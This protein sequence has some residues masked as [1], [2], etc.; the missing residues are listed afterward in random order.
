MTLPN[1]Q[2]MN[3]PCLRINSGEDFLFLFICC[4]FG[5]V[6]DKFCNHL[7]SHFVDFCLDFGFLGN[8]LKNLLQLFG[9]CS[10]G[11]CLHYFIGAFF[12]DFADFRNHPHIKIF[13]KC[14][15]KLLT[16]FSRKFGNFQNLSQN[17]VK[18]HL[19]LGDSVPFSCNLSR[20]LPANLSPTP[21]VSAIT[22]PADASMR[23]KKEIPGLDSC[24][25]AR[26]FRRV[27][28][29]FF[30][31]LPRNPAIASN[32]VASAAFQPPFLPA[33]STLWSSTVS[34]TFS[35]DSL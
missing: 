12:V 33:T 9:I 17:L 32:L 18:I 23:N 24:A 11:I 2:Q 10:L 25:N 8:L 1:L 19:E 5:N 31:S 14:R 3:C 28:S 35:S 15:H 16:F 4:K 7:I 20:N 29:R 13:V 30:L 27:S 6:I 34:L 21:D 22:R 26:I